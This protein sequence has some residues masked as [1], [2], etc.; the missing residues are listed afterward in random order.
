M[1][2]RA[3]ATWLREIARVRP[4]GPV[5]HISKGFTA[6]DCDQLDE[7]AI[8]LDVCHSCGHCNMQQRLDEDSDS[9]AA[10]VVDPRAPTGSRR[11]RLER[12]FHDGSR[13]ERVD[14]NF[15]DP[16]RVGIRMPSGRGYGPSDQTDDGVIALGSR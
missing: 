8:A 14:H 12:S 2:R 9:C 4:S 7:I 13:P 5:G 11:C 15:L 10:I 1:D 16:R 3:M 6:E